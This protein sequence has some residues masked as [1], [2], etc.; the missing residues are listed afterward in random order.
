MSLR[1]L[2]GNLD[3]LIRTPEDVARLNTAIL[4]LALTGRLVAQDQRDG[5]ART[6][7]QKINQRRGLDGRTRSRTALDTEF[8]HDVSSEIPVTWQWT[9]LKDVF[10]V[11]DG[12]HDTP[13]YVSL[14]IPFITSKNLDN[15][16]IDFSTAKMISLQDHEWFSRR[17][18]VE[19]NDI[20]FAMIGSIG[21]PVIVETANFSCKN[22]ALFKYFDIALSCPRYLYYY[23]LFAAENM[24]STS[25]GGVQQF[26]S[27][28]YLRDYP[29]PLPPLAEQHRIVA[30]V[31]ELLAQ[32]RAL[33]ANLRRAQEEIVVVNQAALHR[34]ETA[35]DGESLHAAWRTVAAAFDLLY[36]DPRPLAALRQAILQLAVRG[37]LVRQ[38]EGDEPAEELVRRAVEESSLDGRNKTTAN[39]KRRPDL[40]DQA[41]YLLPTG[42]TICSA[43]DVC[44]SINDGDHIPPPKSDIGVPFLVISNVRRGRLDFANTRFVPRAYYDQLSDARRPRNGDILCSIVGSIG[45]VV[46][47]E[48]A[49]EFCFQRHMALFRPNIA[50][51]PKYLLYL[52]Q[53]PY[54]LGQMRKGAT[55]IAQ[56]T[57]PLSCLRTLVILLPPFAEQKRIAAKVDELLGMCDVL[58]RKLGESA[59]TQRAAV[60]SVLAHAAHA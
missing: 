16:Q 3:D 59:A 21:N 2:F 43:Q 58:E 28:K 6:L 33:E 22:V 4:G 31:D 17:S 38:E 54:L 30:K 29:F 8:N 27:L 55:G 25:L 34:L 35:E 45:T 56:L 12:T 5:H 1:H 53:S 9:T 20:L 40:K 26:V 11:R 60:E 7:L 46:L 13:Q 37:K 36:D 32:T 47:I 19:V 15:G 42:W 49:P 41:N 48:G 18:N 39:T 57:V 23:L 51:Y 50:I 44:L 24:R 14:G 10:D 52:L